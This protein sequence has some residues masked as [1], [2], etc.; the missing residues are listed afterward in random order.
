M[1]EESDFTHNFLDLLRNSTNG[2]KHSREVHWM[3]KRGFSMSV[4]LSTYGEHLHEDE[5]SLTMHT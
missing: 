2:H 3:Q 4:T 5:R 1:L